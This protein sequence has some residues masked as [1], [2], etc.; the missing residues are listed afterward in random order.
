MIG[1]D[2]G[3]TF[4]IG[5]AVVVFGFCIVKDCTWGRKK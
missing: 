2:A 4:M 5:Y 3:L 1:I